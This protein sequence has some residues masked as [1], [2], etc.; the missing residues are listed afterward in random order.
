MKGLDT[1][2]LLRVY[3]ADDPQH[4][5]RA[6]R[7]IARHC[8]RES[9][10]RINRATLCEFVWV[11]RRGY[12]YSRADIAK[13]VRQLLI[14]ADLNIEDADGAHQALVHFEDGYDFADV[15]IGETKANGQFKILEEFKDV[16]GEPFILN[17]L[18]KQLAAKK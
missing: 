7:F 16:A 9:P 15:Y 8:A 12:K 13:L 1:N 10:G 6:R 4:A 11:L 14:A 5:E 17:D 18:D 3:V 2:L